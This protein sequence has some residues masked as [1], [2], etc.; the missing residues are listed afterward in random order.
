MHTYDPFIAPAMAKELQRRHSAT[1]KYRKKRFIGRPF[2]KYSMGRAPDT[3]Q[4]LIKQ[5]AK[6]YRKPM[7][8]VK[9]KPDLPSKY[10]KKKRK[11]ALLK[12][13]PTTKNKPNPLQ[14][15]IPLSNAMATKMTVDQTKTVHEKNSST[16][17]KTSKKWL[18][19]GIAGV[20]VLGT[21]IGLYSYFSK[22]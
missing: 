4:H 14:E 6:P 21:G 15:T 22:Q 17:K 9:I 10:H 5:V 8:I 18:Y 7:R 3:M 13:R 11:Q 1:T 12:K 19:W 16:P 2:P 20:T